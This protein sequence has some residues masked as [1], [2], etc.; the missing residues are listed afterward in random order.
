MSSKGVTSVRQNVPKHFV[1][2][3]KRTDN[4]DVCEAPCS[5]IVWMRSR[6][7]WRVPRSLLLSMVSLLSLLCIEKTLWVFEG[8][9]SE[10]L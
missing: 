9:P 7:K 3:I 8:E 1:L 10:E 4:D 5:Q 6:N 2:Y